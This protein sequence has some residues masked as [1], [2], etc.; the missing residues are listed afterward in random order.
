MYKTLVD[1]LEK[2]KNI[3]LYFVHD[4]MPQK[5]GC[6]KK[7]MRNDKRSVMLY[8]VAV[9]TEKLVKLKMND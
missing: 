9:D 1:I 4:I 2:F 8:L 6:L 7:S 5:S 3:F